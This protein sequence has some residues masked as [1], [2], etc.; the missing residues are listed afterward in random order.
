MKRSALVVASGIRVMVLFDFPAVL[1][2][3]FP[4]SLEIAQ[5]KGR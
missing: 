4:D 3:P 5:N 1:V 2:S